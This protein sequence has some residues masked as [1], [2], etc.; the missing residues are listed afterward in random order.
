MHSV[1][2][3]EVHTKVS[4]DGVILILHEKGA[5][6]AGFGLAFFFFVTAGTGGGER[7][8]WPSPLT[9]VCLSFLVG[10]VSI[11]GGFRSHSSGLLPVLPM[12]VK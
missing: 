6:E 2:T 9:L 3:T 12:T 11:V 4:V 1:L 10:G 8:C 7:K 5:E